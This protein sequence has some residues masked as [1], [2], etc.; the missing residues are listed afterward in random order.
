MVVPRTGFRACKRNDRRAMVYIVMLYGPSRENRNYIG[1]EIIIMC[2]RVRIIVLVAGINSTD[3]PTER[4]SDDN[5]R[6]VKCRH[7]KTL[8]GVW[9]VECVR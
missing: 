1:C 8:G 5:K 2:E 7:V 6:G 9:T 3:L 4:K